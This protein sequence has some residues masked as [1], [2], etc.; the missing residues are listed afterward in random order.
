[1]DTLA[2]TSH[3]PLSEED[4]VDVVSVDL[5]GSA[6]DIDVLQLDDRDITK[7]PGFKYP[8]LLL[9]D[10]KFRDVLR[11]IQQAKKESYR[12][13]PVWLDLQE[14]FSQIGEIQLTSDILLLLKRMSVKTMFFPQEGVSQVIDYSNPHEIEKFI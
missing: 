1:M 9:C 8:A 3:A 5:G 10:V 13:I 4:V 11:V 7:E 6:E 14:E 2:S 12:S